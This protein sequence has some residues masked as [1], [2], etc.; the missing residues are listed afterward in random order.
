MGKS[1]WQSKMIWVNGLTL[2]AGI[3]VTAGGSD[4]IAAHP[5]ISA[6]I[7]GLLGAVNVALRFVTEDP[8]GLD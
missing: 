2:L 5:R 3:L 4:L 8:I 6:A 1:P 7:V